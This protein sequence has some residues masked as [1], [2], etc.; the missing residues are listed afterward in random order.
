MAPADDA[1]GPITVYLK[2]LSAGDASA[3]GAL[4]EAVYA[5]LQRVARGLLASN[6][7]DVSLQPTEL[8]NKVLF[9][10]IRSRSIDWQDRV[11]FFRVASRLLRRR[12]IDHILSHRAAKRPPRHMRVD[13][14]DLLLPDESRFEEI[15]LVHEGL[16]KLAE[17]DYPLAELIEMIYFGG[18]TIQ[19]A[20][21]L[22]GVSEKTIDRHLDF[23]RRWLEKN[24][25]A[26]CPPSVK[27]P[28]SFDR[29]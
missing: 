27:N 9:E 24:F 16:E 22:R 8:V 26:P 2:R 7:K 15:L 1:F 29:P 20:A 10:L 23:A 18:I 17:F 3:E 28:A 21:E 12:M 4:A 6:R 19:M 5:H 13:F 14:D 11:H 25:K